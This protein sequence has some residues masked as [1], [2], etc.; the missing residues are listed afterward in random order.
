MFEVENGS[1]YF[2]YRKQKDIKM[3]CEEMIKE[4]AAKRQREEKYYGGTQGNHY[5][6]NSVIFVLCQML[7]LYNIL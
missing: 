1:F 7:E 3:S 5:H 4:Y 6:K 2:L